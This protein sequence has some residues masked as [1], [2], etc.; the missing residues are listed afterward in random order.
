VLMIAFVLFVITAA[1]PLNLFTQVWGHQFSSAILNVGVL[2]W[3]AL[4][5]GRLGVTYQQREQLHVRMSA[6]DLQSS[7]AVSGVDPDVTEEENE[8]T[9]H[10]LS[11]D[12]N[13]RFL[14]QLGFS[15]WCCR[16]CG[17]WCCSAD[18]SARL[19]PGRWVRAR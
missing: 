3:L 7:A 14:S 10:A 16:P 19:M 6:G 12:G 2:P 18:R 15:P 17:S 9:E 4:A 8:A 11:K 13:L 1:L 5:L